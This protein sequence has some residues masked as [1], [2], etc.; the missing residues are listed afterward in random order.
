[1]EQIVNEFLLPKSE[2]L[3][4]NVALIFL[5]TGPP[6][7]YILTIE[8]G[9]QSKEEAPATRADKSRGGQGDSR[10]KAESR[11]SR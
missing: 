7:R 4:N 1:M 10:R 5:A 8:N 2:N 9:P 3:R 6:V 11:N